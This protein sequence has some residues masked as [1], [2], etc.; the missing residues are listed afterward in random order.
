MGELE[1]IALSNIYNANIFVFKINNNNELCIINQYGNININ[2]RI[3]LTLCYINNNHFIVVYETQKNCNTFNNNYYLNYSFITNKNQNNNI[4]ENIN[5]QNANN[6]IKKVKYEDIEKFVYI[7]KRKGE[8]IYP[9]NIKNISNKKLKHNAKQNFKRS[10]K[11]YDYDYDFNLNR[12]TKTINISNKKDKPNYKTYI[13]SYEFEKVN[14]IKSFHEK[15]FH[16]GINNL[17]DIYS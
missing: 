15:T 7:K 16:K 4:S 5:F 9:N 2:N 13:V 1:I 11:G 6:D 8:L 17:Y 14:L 10:C 12:L 3:L